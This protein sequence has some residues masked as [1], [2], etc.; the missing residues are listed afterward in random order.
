MHL[1]SS[2]NKQV[3]VSFE[4]KGIFDNTVIAAVVTFFKTSE[5]L[6]YIGTN[7]N[8]FAGLIAEVKKASPSTGILREKFD[9]RDLEHAENLMSINKIPIPP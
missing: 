5:L 8:D 4:F 2:N 1:S 6:K 7:I 9:Q 3:C